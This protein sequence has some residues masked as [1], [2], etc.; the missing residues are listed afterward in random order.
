MSDKAQMDHKKKIVKE[1]LH[2]KI[3][4]DLEDMHLIQQRR[5][6]LAASTGVLVLVMVLLFGILELG[7]TFSSSHVF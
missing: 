7:V 4:L 6:T 3:K 5:R 2:R 1:K